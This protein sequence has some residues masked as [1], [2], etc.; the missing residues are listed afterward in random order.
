[1]THD[2]RNV[3]LLNRDRTRRLVVTAALG[4]LF[5]AGGCRTVPERGR[6]EH[7]PG[8]RCPKTAIAPV[9]DGAF[10]E[11]AWQHAERI[12]E[13]SIPVSQEVPLQQTEARIMWDDT[14]LYIVFKTTDQDIWG[15]L[16]SH[17]AGTCREDVCEIFFKTD[18]E[19][20]AYYNF[21]INAL[22][23][24]MDAYHYRVKAGMGHRWKN[25][26]C[27]GIKTGVKIAGTLNDWQDRDEYWQL[28][29]AIPFASLP[30][31]KGR[32]PRPGDRWLFHLARY[33]HSVYLEEG[34]ELASC[35]PL[36]ICSFHFWEDWLPLEFT[37]SRYQSN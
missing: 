34:R 29:V 5:L 6:V 13:F 20:E 26:N 32:I 25:W 22:G 15:L 28:E 21:E 14:C 1:M 2:T 4:A 16:T 12:G 8:Y 27:E 10:D 3:L 33:D 31:L 11:P 7:K 30:G 23:T 9:I 36:S 19:A 24:V 18:P 17:D 37:G 35:A